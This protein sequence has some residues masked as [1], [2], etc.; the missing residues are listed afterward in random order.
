MTI[1]AV[2]FNSSVGM[3]AVAEMPFILVRNRL[4]V[5]A[6]Y[7]MAVY[8][9]FEAVLAGADSLM[10]RVITL[11]EDILHMIP[12]HITRRFNTLLGITFWYYRLGGFSHHT[13]A[14][15]QHQCEKGQ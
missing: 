3:A 4:V 1:K 7:Y 5:F 11:M 2:N 12:T 13:G 8:T 14:A 10:H 9:L 15:N 6:L